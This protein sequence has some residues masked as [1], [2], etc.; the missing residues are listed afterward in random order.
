MDGSYEQWVNMDSATSAT[1]SVA[2]DGGQTD[3]VTRG[4]CVVRT[5]ED[6]RKIRQFGDVSVV[7]A[8]TIPKAAD[9]DATTQREGGTTRITTS[10]TWNYEIDEGFTY[11]LTVLATNRDN[12]A[13]RGGC[14]LQQRGRGGF[15]VGGEERQFPWF[16]T[17][18]ASPAPYSNYQLCARAENDYGASEW[19]FIGEAVKTRP[20]APGAPEHLPA[21][22]DIVEEAYGGHK[23]TRLVWSAAKV[24]GLLAIEGVTTSRPSGQEK[25]AWRP[26]GFR[27]R[28]RTLATHRMRR[29]SRQCKPG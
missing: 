19:A 23:V 3:G 22:S 20:S 16:H 2:D 29:C 21:E 7:W 8:S 18:L 1:A 5:W 17:A 13:L 10:I 6:E 12:A 25:K 11:A 26:T 4:L 9:T 24:T 27:R 14:G 28:V 15:S